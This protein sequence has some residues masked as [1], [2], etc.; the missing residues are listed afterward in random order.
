LT[1]FPDQEPLNAGTQWL[2]HS[3]DEDTNMTMITRDASLNW[4]AFGL[5]L[6][7]WN[8]SDNDLPPS[9]GVRRPADLRAYPYVSVRA[10]NHH[11]TVMN[12]PT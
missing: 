1:P 8:A 6:A 4:I 2:F 5:L 9:A 7:A 12:R 3:R 11:Q 10:A